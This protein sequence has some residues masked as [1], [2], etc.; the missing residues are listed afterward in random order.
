VAP[1]NYFII[2]AEFLNLYIKLLPL[3]VS[4]FG[5]IFSFVI[6]YKFLFLNFNFIFRTFPLYVLIFSFL[7]KKWFIDFLYIKY[8]VR[9]FWF[10]SYYITFKMIDRGILEYFGPLGIVRSSDKISGRL[11]LLHSGFLYQYIFLSIV[12]LICCF[13]FF[14]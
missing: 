8:F 10:L 14:L 13:L 7:S 9:F 1:V 4:F 2:D 5:L 11:M 3:F 12:S 6:Y